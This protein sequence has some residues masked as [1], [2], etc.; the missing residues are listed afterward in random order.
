MI[1]QAAAAAHYRK[2]LHKRIKING[3]VISVQ[4]PA[5]W[6]E[7]FDPLP[8]KRDERSMTD[9]FDDSI[10]DVDRRR[11]FGGSTRLLRYRSILEPSLSD[12]YVML[13]PFRVY[14]YAMLNRKWLPLNINSV[15]DITPDQVRMTAAGYK[16][17][18]LP[19]GHRK[20]LQAIVKNQVRDP[21]RTAGRGE[22][23]GDEFQMDVVKGKGK[24]LIILLHGAPGVGKTSTAEC[25]AAQLQRPL[26]PITCGDVSTDVKEAEETLQE[27]CALAHRWR[28]VLLLD[29]ADVFLAKREK[30]DITRNGLVSGQLQCMGTISLVHML[31]FPQSSSESSNISPAS[32]S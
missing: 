17:L 31:S 16:D 14:G 10:I 13:L 5:D 15:Y 27:Y 2:T 25:M 18:I 29:E 8:A 30:G 23:N 4:T 32:S 22:E 21:K 9:V 20:L 28:C 7:V 24:G 19:R 11:D 26:L 1:D 3:G 6:R 12:D